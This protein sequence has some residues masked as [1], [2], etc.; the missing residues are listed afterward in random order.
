MADSARVISIDVVRDV[1]AAVL[2][3][4]EEARAALVA[5]ESDA[6]RTQTWLEL[7][8]LPHWKAEIIR[9]RELL[10]RAK[11]ELFRAQAMAEMG[12]RGF[13][14]QKK[15]VEKAKRALEEAER[16]LEAT[17]SW[18][19]RFDREA[20][21]F[22]SSVQ[23]LSD[24][25]DLLVPRAV[26]ELERMAERLEQYVAAA[27]PRAEGRAEG[28]PAPA[29]GPGAPGPGGPGRDV[30]AIRAA[31]GAMEP[32]AEGPT[33][34]AAPIGAEAALALARLAGASGGAP[35]GDGETMLLSTGL[36]AGPAALVRV[37]ASDSSGDSG[38]RALPASGDAPPRAV[39][40]TV[41]EVCAAWAGLAPALRLAPGTVLILGP[42][43]GADAYDALGR[44]IAD[45]IRPGDETAGSDA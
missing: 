3:F 34:E 29:G 25:L 7:D 42:G 8:R 44:R 12:R 37:R 20:L 31:A 17:R 43:G 35:P 41:G 16:K 15:A 45:T 9:R 22:R 40:A 39:R 6:R 19:R 21:D 5:A 1:R 32:G 2:A 14:D 4:A 10:G 23:R 26:A 11:S 33:P 36:G 18:I 13:V 28:E 30:E 24:D 38:W 27:P